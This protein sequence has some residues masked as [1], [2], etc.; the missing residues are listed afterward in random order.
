MKRF[1]SLM[2]VAI[3]LLLIASCA[4]AL[5]LPAGATLK[6]NVAYGADP[7]QKMDIYIPA[8]VKRAPVIFMVHGG[9]WQHGD[10]TANDVVTNKVAYFLPH[11][12]VFVSINYRLSPAVTPVQEAQDVASALAY[13]QKN[14]ATYKASASNIVLMGHSAGGN[15]VTLV[16]AVSSYLTQVHAQAVLGTVVLDS[17]AYDVPEVMARSQVLPQYAQV[18]GKNVAL[19]Q[20]ASPTLAIDTHPAPM[21]LVCD[22][23]R[24]HDCDDAKAFAAKTAGS[25]SIYPIALR[26]GDIN[27]DVGLPNA[28]TARIAQFLATLKV[29]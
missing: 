26:H 28:L 14:A 2:L 7:L 22:S 9:G 15:L 13:F 27:L 24:V 3:V 16:A 12:F 1:F 19:E 20:Q 10:K 18:F 5:T 8:G 17:G 25:A 4:D 21:L 6:S 29:N 11:G 23:K